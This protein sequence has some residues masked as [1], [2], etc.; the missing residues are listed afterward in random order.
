MTRDWV[1]T[2]FGHV[3][4]EQLFHFRLD[5]DGTIR[6]RSKAYCTRCGA[7]SVLGAPTPTAEH[8]AAP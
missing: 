7:G 2:L 4:D 3:L 1:C 5:P 6:F 8:P